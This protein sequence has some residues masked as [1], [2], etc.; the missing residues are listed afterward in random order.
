[1]SRIA[2]SVLYAND[3]EEGTF[4]FLNHTHYMEVGGEE[5]RIHP[6]EGWYVIGSCSVSIYDEDG[7]VIARIH[8][9]EDGW[10]AH[11]T[12]K[13]MGVSFSLATF[14]VTTY[15]GWARLIRFMGLAK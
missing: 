14:N 1:M 10:H 6:D 12:E 13:G 11:C 7:Y 15:Q 5:F 3:P 2:F 4:G 8:R 9:T